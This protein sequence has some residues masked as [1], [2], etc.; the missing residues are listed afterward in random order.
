MDIGYIEPGHGSKGRKQWINT[1]EDVVSKHKGKKSILLWAYSLTL[2]QTGR[3]QSAVAESAVNR[4][5]GLQ[6]TDYGSQAH[7]YHVI[8]ATPVVK[9]WSLWWSCF[10]PILYPLIWSH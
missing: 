10:V 5:S 1:D 2:K 7:A 4:I 9:T 6:I 8:L 3:N